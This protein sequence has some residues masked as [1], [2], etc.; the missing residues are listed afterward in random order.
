MWCL[1]STS[2]DRNQAMIYL[3][4]IEL[5]FTLFADQPLQKLCDKREQCGRGGGLFLGVRPKPR[6]EAEGGAFLEETNPGRDLRFSLVRLKKFL[7]SEAAP[8]S[9]KDEELHQGLVSHRQKSLRP[10]FRISLTLMTAT[11]Y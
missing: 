9:G 5:F 2:R 4:L 11:S 1:G 7:E 3:L 6:D 8:E 10:M